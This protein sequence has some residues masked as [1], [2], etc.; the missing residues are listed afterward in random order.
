MT[1]VQTCALPIYNPDKQ[2]EIDKQ[3]LRINFTEDEQRN[4]KILT[5][6]S[7]EF[8]NGLLKSGV[9]DI[10]KIYIIDGIVKLYIYKNKHQIFTIS[11][12]RKTKFNNIEII[13]GELEL[14]DI[15]STKSL[16]MADFV[17][18]NKECSVYLLPRSAFIKLLSVHEFAIWFTQICINKMGE[19]HE[20][21][22]KLTYLQKEV[23]KT[24][25]QSLKGIKI[26]NNHCI[27]TT[28]KTTSIA[29]KSDASKNYVSDI[30]KKLEKKSVLRRNISSLE[31]YCDTFK[32]Y[33]IDN[34][35]SRDELCQLYKLILCETCK[36]PCN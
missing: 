4:A 15:E 33:I 25:I 36:Y 27:I 31:I 13:L 20:S 7:E 30:Y 6:K 3:V 11:N 18:R 32:K 22:R 2:N 10:D 9:T 24:I 17:D 29:E 19:R 28:P 35:G 26:N 34:F 12:S 16:V 23:L 8:R 14:F 1:G 21:I 5:S